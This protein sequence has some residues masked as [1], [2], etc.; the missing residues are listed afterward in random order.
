MHVSQFFEEYFACFDPDWEPETVHTSKTECKRCG[1]HYHLLC[2]CGGHMCGLPEKTLIYKCKQ[3]FTRLILEDSP[4]DFKERYVFRWIG[5]GVSIL[6]G[7]GKLLWV[8]HAYTVGYRDREKIFSK[9]IFDAYPEG[10]LS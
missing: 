10:A 3:C 1:K 5:D 8:D 9:S 2:P 6:V 4:S 7:D